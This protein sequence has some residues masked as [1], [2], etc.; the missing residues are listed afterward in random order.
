MPIPDAACV[1]NITL[2]YVLLQYAMVTL[3]AYGFLDK[4]LGNLFFFPGT[5][6]IWRWNIEEN[7]ATSSAFRRVSF[8]VG[9]TVNSDDLLALKR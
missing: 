3:C 4:S 6:M 2:S 9:K 1:T 5:C 8:G 7:L